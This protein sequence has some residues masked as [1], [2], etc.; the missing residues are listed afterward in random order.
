MLILAQMIIIS[1]SVI[2]CF[3]VLWENANKKIAV[4]TFLIA[5]RIN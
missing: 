2:V 5:L 1:I 4:G 3:Q